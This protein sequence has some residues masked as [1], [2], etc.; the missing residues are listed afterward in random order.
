MSESTRKLLRAILLALFVVV[1]FTMV[2][3][4]AQDVLP[5][6]PHPQ[7]K[8]F[9]LPRSWEYSHGQHAGFFT[10]RAKWQDPPLR[11]NRQV[12]RSPVWWISQSALWLTTI[13]RGKNRWHVEPI[14]AAGMFG[15]DYLSERLFCE[16]YAVGPPVYAVIQY[17]VHK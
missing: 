17:A 7:V 4:C 9:K 12:L 14:E 15:F 1:L 11:T 6:A 5:D 3:A 16:C 8:S 13:P 10:F 2:R